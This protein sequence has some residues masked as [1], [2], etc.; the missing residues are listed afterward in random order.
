MSVENLIYKKTWLF[1]MGIILIGLCLITIASQG[2]FQLVLKYY[3]LQSKL[4]VA[5]DA[6]TM[7][8]YER[9]EE[10]PDIDLNAEL[11]SVMSE[12][13]K[14][15]NVNVKNMTALVPSINPD[16]SV[17]TNE[18][19]I[20]G[21]F[22]NSLKCLDYAIGHLKSVKLTSVKF[23]RYGTFKVNALS[24]RVYFQTIKRKNATD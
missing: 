23:E 2:T 19:V 16:Y 9:S 22:F 1:L 10:L 8:S 17:M 20:E 15:Y 21:G 5:Q 3:D 11:F 18:V 24:T 6:P 12:S 4:S 13:A 14:A 7:K